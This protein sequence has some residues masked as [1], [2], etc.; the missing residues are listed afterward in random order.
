M[1]AVTAT[2]PVAVIEPEAVSELE[3]VYR[4]SYSKFL[5]TATAITGTAESG[6]DAV[7]DAFVGL[8]RG[9]K[10]YRGRGSVEAWAWRAV[11]NSARKRRQGERPV[12]AQ[13][14]AS[15]AVDSMPD[16]SSVDVEA[17][18]AELARMPERQRTA[19]FLRYYADLDYAGIATVLGLRIGSIGATLNAAHDHLRPFLEG[20]RR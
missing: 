7:H 8:V 3:R 1:E 6:Q 17:L 2:N 19:L 5:R 9:Q 13:S 12:L 15:G 20:V 4:T 10:G 14:E 18:R 16:D 11:I